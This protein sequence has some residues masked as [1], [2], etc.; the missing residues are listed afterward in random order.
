MWCWQQIYPL[1]P[2]FS[3]FKNQSNREKLR[4]KKGEREEGERD[5]VSMAHFP[6][7][8]DIQAES[9]QRQKQGTTFVSAILVAGTHRIIISGFLGERNIQDFNQHS[10]LDVYLSGNVTC[11]TTMLATPFFSFH[12]PI[13]LLFTYL[14]ER[15]KDRKRQMIRNIPTA[16]SVPKG[17]WGRPRTKPGAQK[18]SS[19]PSEWQRVNNWSC[20]LLPSKGGHKKRVA[21]SLIFF[22]STC[23]SIF[24]EY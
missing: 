7:A 5:L 3:H 22:E 23:V 10:A 9:G 24:S 2:N 1:C 20:Q 11:S 12:E 6:K 16:D 13:N 19:F 21:F 14:R 15:Q 17:S 4:D 8:Y 18:S